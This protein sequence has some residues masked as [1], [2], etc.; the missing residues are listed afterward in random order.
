M[1]L[2]NKIN[3]VINGVFMW[4]AGIVLA[5]MIILACA[6]IFCRIVW[7]PI[8]GT[9]ELM[10]Y[11]GAV[12]T[13]FALGYTQLKKGHIAVDIVILGFPKKVQRILNAINCG[14]CVGFFIIVGWQIWRYATNLWR[15]GEVT[16]T[17]RIIYYPFTYAVALGCFALA[18][19]FLVEL[20]NSLVGKKED[21]K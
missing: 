16:E 14:T 18:F 4:V 12:I 10:G 8:R 21:G 20:L 5:T 17:L 13:A 1:E 15:T 2:L 9:F 3:R 6:N 11:F 19:V 7:L